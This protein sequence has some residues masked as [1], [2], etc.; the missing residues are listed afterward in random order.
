MPNKEPADAPKDI[1]ESAAENARK[2]T[3]DP[4][5]APRHHTVAPG[6][7][8]WSISRAQLGDGRRF[9]EIVRLNKLPTLS[10]YPGQR[11]E[12]PDK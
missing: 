8:I 11:L 12:L 2:G 5:K 4:P 3:V 9:P 10:V 7:T 1:P 6:E